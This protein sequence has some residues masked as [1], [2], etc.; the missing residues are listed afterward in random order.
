MIDDKKIE[1]IK[2]DFSNMVGN[3]NI[4]IHAMAH[5][6]RNIDPQ[7]LEENGM[8]EYERQTIQINGS[9][10]VQEWRIRRYNAVNNTPQYYTGGRVHHLRSIQMCDGDEW[11]ELFGREILNPW[12]DQYAQASL[13]W[14]HDSSRVLFAGQMEVSLLMQKNLRPGVHLAIFFIYLAPHRR[15]FDGHA[16]QMEFGEGSNTHQIVSRLFDPSDDRVIVQQATECQMLGYLADDDEAMDLLHNC[17]L[18]P[19][20]DP[21]RYLF[22]EPAPNNYDDYG[23]YVQNQNAGNIHRWHEFARDFDEAQRD[24]Q[25]DAQQRD[26]QQPDAQQHDAQRDAQP[27]IQYEAEDDNLIPYNSDDSDDSD[28]DENEAG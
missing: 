20:F 4:A 11:N 6:D 17:F 22:V 8:N 1:M 9:A 27:D 5:N 19:D 18:Q 24:A 28:D 12:L 16:I 7:D 14:V 25:P 2:C 15:S 10:P 21:M 23:V 3:P 26:A 13:D